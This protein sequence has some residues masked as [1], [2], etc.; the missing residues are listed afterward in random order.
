MT[1][2]P[3]VMGSAQAVWRAAVAKVLRGA[4]LETLTSR[5]LDGIEVAPLYPAYQG[6]DWPATRPAG[7]WR[8]A[9][10]IDDPDLAEAHVQALADLDGGA[11][12]LTLVAAGAPSAR[13]FGLALDSADD[14]DAILRD[15]RLDLIELRLDPGL[16]EFELADW[17]A[18]A[19]ERRGHRLAGLAF[20]L[21]IDPAG[22]LAT[23]GALPASWP[24]IGARMA[25]TLSGL[26]ERS[27]AGKA[28]RA[29]GRP[30][31]EA[32]AS[33]AQ[34]LAA[35]LASAVLYM[36]ALEA[37]GI[38]L[39]R[40]RDALSF[41]LVADADLV[42]T[43]AKFRALRR[44]WAR[45]EEACGLAPNPLR[46][47]G[48]SAWRMMTVSSPETNMI[49]GAVA[50]FAASAGGTDGIT[51]LPFTTAL[52]LPDAFARR[53]ARNTQHVLAEES[54]LWRVADPAGGAGTFEALTQDLCEKA[55]S[56]FQEI[57]REGGIVESLAAGH[58]QRRIA[59]VRADREARL[60]DGRDALVGATMF[61][62]DGGAAPAV[63]MR[64]RPH[65]MAVA[66]GPLRA[67]TLVSRRAAEPFEGHPGVSA[68]P[69]H[70]ERPKE[71][72]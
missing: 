6:A 19:V 42:L 50:C 49:R 24:E 22:T 11:D 8:I 10:R 54:N 61:R 20:D 40:A 5:T 44:L 25:S 1:A 53:L 2:D 28:F 29:D 36:R 34:E 48:E 23:A 55:W 21:G 18:E 13:G 59:A 70:D 64:A 45:A 46:L 27:F 7:R 51:V 31:H 72:P 17:V 12:S 37:G 14:L 68:H 3:T 32:G 35:V 65:I 57:E 58:V 63:L 26:S 66:A 71:D 38:K 47:H 52:G 4:G 30:W 9:Q 60:A 16:Q 39:D 67:E 43:V 62:H 15:V 33:E 56:L 69:A 41:L